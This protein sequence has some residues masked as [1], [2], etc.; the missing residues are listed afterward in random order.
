M[1][2]LEI[3]ESFIKFFAERGHAYVRSSS[4]VP[5]DDPTLLFTNAG[6]VQFKDCFLGTDVRNYNRAV[7][8]QKS[9]RISGKHNDLENV[10]RTARHHTFFEMLG[11]FSFGDY[12]KKE[13]IQYAWSFLTETLN[14]PKNRLWITIYEEDDEAGE[15]WKTLTDVNPE[16]ILR[17]GKDDNFWA[18]GETG[19][20]GPCSEIHYYLGEDLNDQSEEKFRTIDGLFIEI[21]N[22][23]FMQF[24]R[25]PQG[26][27][28]PLPKPSVD[29][30]MGLERISAV[31][32]GVKANY[33][34]DLLRGIIA[35]TEKLCGKTYLGKDY[36]IRDFASDSQYATDVALRVISDH[37]RAVSFL[38]AD[39]VLPA[40]DGRGYVLR[41]L[42]RRACRY[43]K[44]LG[45]KEPFL[46]KVVGHVQEV[47][48]VT[49][50]ELKSE[51]IQKL[52]KAEEEKFLTTLDNGLNTLKKEVEIIKG[53][54][55]KIFSGAT[56]FLLHDSYGFPLDLTE[57][58]LKSEGLTVDRGAFEKEMSLQRERSRAVRATNLT[59][60]R[61]VKAFPTEF[62]GYQYNEYESSILGI[63]NSDGE[64]A[65]AVAGDEIALVT[66]ETPF[67][68]ESG[69]QLGDTG[70]ITAAGVVIDVLD[71]QKVAGGTLVHIARILEGEVNVGMKEK[72]RLAIDTHRR[73]NIA[74]HHSVTHLLHLALRTICGDHVKQAGSRVADTG[75]RFDFNHFE[76][77]SPST[78]KEIEEFVNVRIQENAEVITRV[79]PIEEAKKIGAMALFGE[80]YGDKVRVVQ[81]GA[82]SKEFC[83]GTHVSRA[84]DIGAFFLTAESAVSAGVRRVEA[85]AGGSAIEKYSSTRSILDELLSSFQCGEKQLYERAAQL[86]ERV[87][88]LEKELSRLKS[89]AQ[90][91]TGAKLA[92]EA[93]TLANGIKVVN[94]LVTDTSAKALRELADDLRNRMQ[95]GG[96]I[97]LG[98]VIDG[99]A[100]LLTAVT[101]DLTD[102][103]HA[104]KLVDELS[105]IVGGKGGG[106]ADLAQAGGGDP[107]LLSEAI[108]KF[109]NLLQ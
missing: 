92:A 53:R 78:R 15:L 109:P 3:R 2:T 94:Q 86:I 68:G 1:N 99:K 34:T 28:T 39:G 96:C 79:L 89:S 11:N 32:Q 83:G 76:G 19:P 73:K 82:D 52:V 71:T 6:M 26:K 41:R 98:S 69:G 58:I 43:G 95:T 45:F 29:T 35:T 55:G 63:F 108:A 54:S 21:W 10:G 72:L 75:L 61:N 85:V 84:G 24:N 50:P 42:V 20:C 47:M 7:T 31:K 59:L 51:K 56:A 5:G 90:S 14:L 66:R 91:S 106:K 102:R 30:G 81:I 18:M 101:S 74:V 46:Y 87:S 48:S 103:Y 104:G 44:I 22:L 67:Y 16:R 23:V 12:F 4:L 38:I 100:I 13:A 40:S 27:L 62:V 65:K 88:M 17:C 64:V 60:Q 9:L 49:Y 25:D 57:D 37:S 8:C 36:T 97:V 107:A 70:R 93:Q 33:D 77:L 105:K 80:K